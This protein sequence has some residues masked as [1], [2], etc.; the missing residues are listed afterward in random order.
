MA[1]CVQQCPGGSQLVGFPQDE[2]LSKRWSEAIRVGTG[3]TPTTL[4]EQDATEEGRK[5]CRSHFPQP[6]ETGYQEPTRF[7]NRQGHPVELTSCRL[8]LRFLPESQMFSVDGLICGQTIC[9]VI[10]Q[11]LRIR[12]K[13]FEFLQ[14]ICLGCFVKLDMI[15]T[16]Q[17]QFMMRD[18]TYRTLEMKKVSQEPV[19]KPIEVKAEP[20]SAMMEDVTE[21]AAVDIKI[22]P[23]VMINVQ[24]EC[25]KL[26]NSPKPKK[27]PKVDAPK[28]KKY[29]SKKKS[30]E[31]GS[32]QLKQVRLTSICAKTCYI[33]STK[34]LFETTD[35]LYS[36]LTEKHAGQIDYVC[37][38]CDDK[39]FPLVSNYNTH[40][41]LHDPDERP[42]K[43][44]FCAIRYSTKRAL[45]V[46]E[47]RLHETNHPLPKIIR[48]KKVRPQCEQCGK[49]FPSLGRAREHQLVE[50]ENG[51][52]AE[53]KICLKTFATIANLR[54]H[55][56]V[57]SKEHPYECN[58]CGVR[59]RVSTDL[60]K[61]ILADHQ[62]KTA[63]HCTAC[64]M[65]FKTKNEYY[66]HRNR[67][68]N[69]TTL[70]PFRCRLCSEVPL[71]S[72]DLTDHI[73]S[74]HPDEVYPYKQ[75]PDCPAKYFTGMSL[76]LHQRTKHG[77]LGKSGLPH[78]TSYVCDLCG[79]KYKNRNSLKIH[80]GNEHD[81]ERKYAC[82]VCD[83]R[84]AFRSNLSRHLQ[85]H[86]EIKR[87]ACDFCD[88]TFA[89]KTAMMNH[90]RNIHTGET[91]FDCPVCGAAFKESSTYYRHKAVCK[92][93]D[94]QSP[95][96]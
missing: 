1:C 2:W 79:K 57:H 58:I 15:R 8:C 13:P 88:R 51:V 30:I 43:C 16:M 86:E 14:H 3:T 28:K 37:V 68:H 18:V 39:K 11:S 70:K 91:A 77:K 35:E 65:P 95:G 76:G 17:S 90:R 85:M 62:G 59:Y 12:L 6:E 66:G 32:I 22:E 87:F 29:K 24:T 92:G 44:N 36:H 47:N 93:R 72:R 19:H 73:E 52:A 80:M 89:Q 50:H 82:E 34:T 53:C 74:C 48:S 69:K 46:H 71:N 96:Q 20:V 38:L 83:K 21:H 49:F 61:H 40:L 23:E 27:V 42:M 64:N 94:G 67:V 25:V 63:Y 31:S 54:R 26:R 55:M 4:S 9:T 45:L 84:F 10:S 75:C 60:S 7:V 33:C 41:S 5:I 81:G 78:P 56:V